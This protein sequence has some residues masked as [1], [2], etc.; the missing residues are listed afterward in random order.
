MFQNYGLKK[1]WPF[2]TNFLN[3]RLSKQSLA[4]ILTATQLMQGDKVCLLH[5]AHAAVLLVKLY[6]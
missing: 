3:L 1:S 2:F 6:T 5:A 4:L